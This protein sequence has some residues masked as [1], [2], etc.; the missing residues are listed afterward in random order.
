MLIN[1]SANN[2]AIAAPIDK[3]LGIKTRFKKKFVI[4]PIITEIVKNFSLPV[5]IKYNIPVKL[6]IPIE[7]IKKLSIF[8]RGTTS[9]QPLP[10]NHG[11]KLLETETI[12]RHN[13][14]PIKK[15]KR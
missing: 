14:N 1:D 8:N 5:G 10:K 12:P 7:I 3:N 9:L 11:T 2:D 15:T 6:L 13:G 4:A